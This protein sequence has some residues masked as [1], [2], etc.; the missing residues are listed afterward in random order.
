VISIPDDNARHDA[1]ADT[2]G[3]D[4]DDV[5]TSSAPCQQ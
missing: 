3:D 4:V 5:D 2:D 1:T